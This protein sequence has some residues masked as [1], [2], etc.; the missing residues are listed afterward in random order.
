MTFL[1]LVGLVVLF[2]WSSLFAVDQRETAILLQ[3]GKPLETENGEP[4]PALEPG[5]HYKWPFVQ[6]AIIFDTRILVYDAQP[7]EVLTLDKKTLV[8]DNYAKW[9]IVDPLV[10]YNKLATIPR[11]QARLDD[12]I[13]SNLREA[14]GRYTMEDI[15]SEERDLIMT[16][17]TLRSAEQVRELGIEILDVRIKRTDLP[18]ENERA[19]YDRMKAEREQQAKQYRAEGDREYAE[20]TAE[21]DKERTIILAEAEREAQII[22]GQG[23]ANATR[24]YAEALSLDEDFYAFQRSLEAY[25]QSFQENTRIILSPE[26]S[27]FLR[28]FTTPQ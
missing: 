8:V 27:R 15:V 13:Y 18:A 14:L 25:V 22:R 5:L 10:F 20:I 3:F 9:R 16:N 26:D 24:I 19:I 28:F 23:D 11:A 7:A 17:V 12:I 21:A 1:V 2:L 6:R 4:A